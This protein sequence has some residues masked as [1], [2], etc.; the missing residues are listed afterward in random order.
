MILTNH[1]CSCTILNERSFIRNLGDGGNTVVI[2][3]LKGVE[4]L[5]IGVHFLNGLAYG[6]LLALIAVGLVLIFG[7]LGIVNF[8]HGAI[9]ML[10]AYIAFTV[11]THTDSFWLSLIVSP[12]LVGGMGILVERL[13]LRKMQNI[14]PIYSA[15]F[16]F[17]LALAI[18]NFVRMIWGTTSYS[19]EA[20]S[21]LQGS[22]NLFGYPYP[23]YR[24]FVILF[25]AILCFVMY[26]LLFRSRLGIRMRAA[27]DDREMAAALGLNVSTLGVAVFGIG[28]ALAA[29]AGVI[30]GPFLSLSPDMGVYVIVDA[31]IIIVIGGMGNFLGAIVSAILIGFVQSIGSVFMP[32][33]SMVFVYLV[34]ILILVVNA[35]GLMSMIKKLRF[36]KG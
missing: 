27:T 34:M 31:F 7:F 29:V 35:D 25:S 18:E 28:C 5:L 12:L 23:A 2:H 36:H 16:T 21:F 26:Y 3:C 17:G 24:L 30:A 8:A 11:V 32:Q 22:V 1:R 4:I 10:G 9:Y 19:P 15:L 6:M 14:D 13:L 33:F 20:P